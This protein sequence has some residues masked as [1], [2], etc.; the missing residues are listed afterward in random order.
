MQKTAGTSLFI[1][2][3]HQF[4]QRAMYPTADDGPQE[5]AV[6]NTECVVERFNARRDEVRVVTGHFPL[7]VTELLGVPFS[8]F[9]VLRR[10]GRTDAVVPASSAEARTRVH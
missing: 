2:M 9:T 7:C 1:R 5:E 8:T 4:G 10:P 3:R 6:L